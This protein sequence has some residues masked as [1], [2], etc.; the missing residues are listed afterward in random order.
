MLVVVVV[1]LLDV[2]L[3]IDDPVGA[4]AVHLANGVWGTLAAGLFATSKSAAGI[5]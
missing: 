3:H 2:K 5:D 4:V 1:L